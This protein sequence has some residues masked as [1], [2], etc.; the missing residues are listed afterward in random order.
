MSNVNFRCSH[1]GQLLTV[2]DQHLGMQVRCPHCQQ[3]VSAP[4]T[5]SGQPAPPFAPV[6]PPAPLPAP[7]PLPSVLD[8]TFTMPPPEKPEEHESIFSSPNPTQTDDLFGQSAAKIEMPTDV[9]APPLVPNFELQPASPQH[10]DGTLAYAPPEATQAFAPGQ[11]DAPLPHLSA[12]AP[13]MPQSEPTSE[14]VESDAPV[15]AETAAILAR[16]RSR[17]GWHIALFIIPLISYAALA[18][19]AVIILWS[20]LQGKLPHP[21]KEMPDIEGDHPTRKTDGKMTIFRPKPGQK[22]PD[23]LVVGLGQ[24]LKLGDLEV[25]PLRIERGPIAIAAEKK[26]NPGETQL[27]G[28]ALKLHLRFKNLSNDLSFYPMDRFFTRY[29][30]PGGTR[31]RDGLRRWMPPDKEPYTMLEIGGNRFYGGPAGFRPPGKDPELLNYENEFVKGQEAFENILAPGKEMKTFVCTDP[32]DPKLMAT[33]DGFRGEMRWRVQVRRGAVTIEGRRIPC[34]A[35]I[36]VDF[37]ASDIKDE[38]GG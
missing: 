19:V 23:E 28:L 30:V 26:D 27:D 17:S 21:L 10:G 5:A 12:Q 35:V 4:T 36:G 18:T 31:V 38:K 2:S 15:D 33:L 6:P 22:M 37:T 25:E 34:T 13:W 9:I 1:C 11:G 8:A 14:P 16:P 7:A 32:E 20:R 3:V 24:T 29:W